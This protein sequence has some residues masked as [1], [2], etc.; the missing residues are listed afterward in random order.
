[1]RFIQPDWSN[2]FPEQIFEFFP[3]EIESFA[4]F[5]FDSSS[6]EDPKKQSQTNKQEGNNFENEIGGSNLVYNNNDLFI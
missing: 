6:F 3:N 1:M 2:A 4:V 5:G